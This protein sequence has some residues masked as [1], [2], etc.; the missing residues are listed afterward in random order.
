MKNTYIIILLLT[1][2]FGNAYSQTVNEDTLVTPNPSGE[3]VALYRYLYDMKGKVILSGQQ[4]SPWGIDEFSY[5]NTNTGKQPAIK[6]M[7]FITGYENA[8]EI[9]KAINWWNNGGIPTIMWHWGAP[10]KGDGYEQSKMAIEIDRCFIDGTEEY[11]A[12]WA[13]L[14]LKA[15]LLQVLRDEHI[16]VLWR[17]YH[18]LNGNWFWWGKQ[19]G[20][21]FKKLWI[22]MFNYFVYERQLNNLIWVLCYTGSP[23]AAWYPGDQYVDI[24]GADTYNTG[25][26]PQMTMFNKVKT[27]TNDKF[28]LAYHECGIPPNP[29][30]C[31]LQGGMWS[32]WMEWH[33]DWLTGVDKTYLDYVYN[34]EL[35]ITLDEVPDIMKIYGWDNDS[36]RASEVI[37]GVEADTSGWEQTTQIQVAGG[38]TAVLSPVVTDSGSWTWSGLGTSGNSPLQTIP[39]DKAGYVTGIFTNTCGASTYLTYTIA[40]ICPATL[41]SPFCKTAGGIWE[42]T[43]NVSVKKGQYVS[44]SPQPSTGGFWNWTGAYTGTARIVTFYPDTTCTITG[45]FTNSCGRTS[46][47]DFN[48]TVS[49]PTGTDPEQFNAGLNLFP[50]P[51]NDYLNVIIKPVLQEGPITLQIYSPVGKLVMRDETV[52][53]ESLLD[54][55]NLAGG[56]Y[57]LKIVSEG[58]NYGESFIKMD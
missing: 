4:D 20:A 44:F 32:W 17:P 46:A 27:I 43:N 55:S 36:C 6:G 8:N 52:S 26:G 7:D 13:E 34:H 25:D 48:I 11:K 10:T 50:S 45:T 38:L 49:D 2:A 40:D 1:T 16:P 24:A 5:I 15:D 42:N 39:I 18:E 53:D 51:C 9:Q 12:F 29:D 28:P 56:I 41:I 57:F 23:D 19:G 30:Q 47:M 37:P 33:T 54:V 3:A 35:T 21:K 31:L 22:T 58:V 14:K